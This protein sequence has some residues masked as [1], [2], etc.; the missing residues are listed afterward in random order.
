LWIFTGYFFQLP[1][2]AVRQLRAVVESTGTGGTV[3][4]VDVLV[5]VDVVEDV[6]LVELVELVVLLELDVL[7]LVVDE[8]DVVLEV[9]VV[10]DVDVVLD[11]DVVVLV[12]VVVVVVGP[13]MMKRP[14]A[15]GLSPSARMVP[16]GAFVAVS[17]MVISPFP[18]MA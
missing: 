4:V 9:V 13:G 11:V 16:I 6:L 2:I 17:M 1:A 18:L 14:S 5:E 8:V 15:V 7:V 10:D 3:D 12:G